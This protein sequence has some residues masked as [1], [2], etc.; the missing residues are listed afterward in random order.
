MPSAHFFRGRPQKTLCG[1]LVSI[2]D[3]RDKRIVTIGGLL[4]D[5]VTTWAL[6]AG[7]LPKEAHHIESDSDTLAETDLNLSNYEESV[8]PP[9]IILPA[10]SFVRD[11][12]EESDLTGTL[13][14][15]A[16]QLGEIEIV[17][18]EWSLIR[19]EDASLALPNCV[20]S[21]HQQPCYLY[22]IAEEPELNDANTVGNLVTILGGVTGTS[23]MR[24][25]SVRSPM[26]LPGGK[27]VDAW[28]GEAETDS[29]L[30][31]G[32]SGSWVVDAAQGIVYGHVLSI[33]GRTVYVLPLADVLQDI[34]TKLPTNRTVLLQPFTS[35]AELA[36]LHWS[37]KDHSQAKEYAKQA[38]QLHV[39]E[40]FQRQ[41]A[42]GAFT[43]NEFIQWAS[44]IYGLEMPDIVY[45]DLQPQ[46]DIALD[47][48]WWEKE[49]KDLSSNPYHPVTRGAVR[50]QT[51]KRNPWRQDREKSRRKSYRGLDLKEKSS[52]SI[53][54]AADT[55][56]DKFLFTELLKT[57][58]CIPEPVDY[59]EILNY[60]EP[61]HD[62]VVVRPF[63]DNDDFVD[64]LARRGRFQ[65]KSPAELFLNG[66]RLIIQQGAMHPQAFQSNVISLEL[67][68]YEFLVQ[69]MKLPFPA[70]EA[71]AT[72]GPFLW[73]TRNT[74]QA[75]K[76]HFQ[77]VFRKSDTQWSG[78]G[79]RGFEMMLSH[80]FETRITSG[81]VRGTHHTKIGQ[82]LQ[83]LAT[84]STSTAHPLLL[85]ILVLCRELGFKND[86][87]HQATRRWI[88][89]LEAT[90]GDRY[91]VDYVN[92]H[93][94]TE[95]LLRDIGACQYQVLQK[96]PQAWLK[97]VDKLTQA[98]GCYWESLDPENKTLELE[99]LHET[100]LGRLDFF[101]TKLQGLESYIQVSSERLKI[102][103]EEVNHILAL[104]E[105]RVS[106]EMATQ[107][108]R[109]A[110]I[111]K[112]DSVSMKSITLLTMFFLPGTF[113]ASIFSTNFF[114]FANDDI[115][116]VS[117]RVW[118]YFVI[119]IP[120]TVLVLGAW[121]GY[122]RVRGKKVASEDGEDEIRISNPESRIM[123]DIRK[124][125]L[126][127]TADLAWENKV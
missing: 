110:R 23:K 119:V 105:S 86:E 108:R 73:W 38:L 82:V 77:L 17:G 87:F 122:D 25:L 49:S 51:N 120:L 37:K 14:I 79:N 53:H 70:L 124:W 112:E 1:A 89:T 63:F 29:Q 99:Q 21:E 40:P 68:Q 35:L 8:E 28:V 95:Q 111:S 80:S 41:S 30:K 36:K 20:A 33:A 118:V 64:F 50:S 100:L 94:D 98:M 103:R 109:I 54:I 18:D 123:E 76:S 91:H 12:V 85:P 116:P 67:D 15:P 52:W 90:L 59:L 81:Y 121:W 16:E 47:D 97:V 66:T 19:L 125:R 72:A 93:T 62:A 13:E 126:G 7:H 48:K 22:T 96:R 84:C 127:E 57:L 114:D 11:R 26:R 43:A 45:P 75:E 101:T 56:I 42:R 102:L 69:E 44:S 34:S 83:Q 60:S 106:L 9:L 78:G 104:R 107:H 55:H 113:V 58:R 10:T 117:N 74:K 46:S 115:N 31:R 6:T 4:T 71:S 27:W 24:L 39:I 61:R 2:G 3:G 32:D 5:G 88:C 65:P 92:N